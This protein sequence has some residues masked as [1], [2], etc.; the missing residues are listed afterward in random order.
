MGEKQKETP[1][2]S[3]WRKIE[4]T[5][6]SMVLYFIINDV[7]KEME[8]G[9][10]GEAGQLRACPHCPWH[11]VARW[12]CWRGEGNHSITEVIKQ[13]RRSTVSQLP[14]IADCKF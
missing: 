2:Y 9:E 14:A 10:A 1:N 12:L 11:S 6:R 13:S 4:I 5:L 8:E 7:T 3:L